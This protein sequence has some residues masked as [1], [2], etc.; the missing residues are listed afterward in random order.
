MSTYHYDPPTVPGGG[1]RIG[2]HY[3]MEAMQCPIKWALHNVL[4]PHPEAAPPGEVPVGGITPHHTAPPLLIGSLYHAGVEGWYRSR[5][6]DGVDTGEASLDVAMAAL[7]AEYA[8][9]LREWADPFDG[10]TAL[11]LVRTLV[12]RYH[13]WYGPNGRRP[14]HPALRVVVDGEGEPMLEREFATALGADAPDGTPYILTAR[15]DGLVELH[16]VRLVDERKTAASPQQALTTHEMAAQ[17]L[18]LTFLANTHYT[19]TRASGINLTVAHKKYGPTSKL[20]PFYRTTFT[21]TPDAVEAFRVA[22]VDALHE[23]DERVGAWHRLVGEGMDPWTAMVACFPMRGRFVGACHSYGR[24]CA[25]ARL[26]RAPALAP[27]QFA[28]YKARTNPSR[29]DE[30]L[31]EESA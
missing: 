3:L 10:S 20:D 1:S 29:L 31:E 17:M 13:D 19:D 9:R 16:G 25:Y 27:A 6:R 8:R 26:C 21:Y 18:G 11:D 7:D 22:A 28:S 23:I 15:I 5:V 30:A 14:E 4:P 12:T 24:E 2:V